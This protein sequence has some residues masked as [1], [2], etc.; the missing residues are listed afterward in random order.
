MALEGSLKDID[1]TDL[2]QVYS[3]KGR[4]CRLTTRYG[5]LEGVIFF[6]EGNIIH[7]SVGPLIGENAFVQLL[8]W[9]DGSFKIET[10][11]EGDV[12]MPKVTIVKDTRKL[13]NEA[14][15]KIEEGEEDEMLNT[16]KERIKEIEDVKDVATLSPSDLW[17]G[18]KIGKETFLATV[19]T[20]A[21]MISKEMG[22]GEFK[23]I[24]MQGD[25]KNGLV[26][27]LGSGYLV[28]WIK[29]TAVVENVKAEIEREIT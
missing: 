11:I 9:K 21:E 15:V 24:E 5:S 13:I 29:P 7:A 6:H 4:T 20:R 16:L 14:L 19:C 17:V 22:M 12:E 1:I 2:V 25:K 3:N 10:D 18:K 23:C 27:K 26:Y 28:A 8:K